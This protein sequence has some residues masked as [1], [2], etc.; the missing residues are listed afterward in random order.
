[1]NE[2]QMALVE[3]WDGWDITG[4]YLMEKFDG[5]RAYWDGEQFWTRSG[6]V[7]DAPESITSAMPSEHVDGEIW[8]GRGGFPK[9]STA[10]RFGTADGKHWDGVK[11][12]PFDYPQRSGDW[13]SRFGRGVVCES[14]AH[15]V[16]MMRDIQSQG[17]EGVIA[18][19]PG[20]NYATGRSGVVV[21]IK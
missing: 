11:F 14:N 1:M 17:G 13:R 3:D 7:I 10:T 19:Q 6:N 5:C 21:R 20:F 12:V 2:S 9:A 16:D 4:W 15:A 8:A 18:R